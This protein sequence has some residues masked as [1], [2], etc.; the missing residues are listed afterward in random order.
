MKLKLM[1]PERVLIEEKAAKI[2]AR[3]QNGYFCLLPR[4]VDFVSALVPGILSFE[5]AKG[6]NRYAAIGEGTL[7]KCGDEV[8]IST[9]HA[10]QGE[11]LEELKH[12]VQENYL[13]PGKVESRAR[14]IADAWQAEFTST[15]L[16][17]KAGEAR[18]NP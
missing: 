5:D 12:I 11:D 4:H 16:K 13:A 9:R 8:L 14:E 17:G 6:L 7:V 1:I 15:Y 10:T 3:G 18:S 2:T